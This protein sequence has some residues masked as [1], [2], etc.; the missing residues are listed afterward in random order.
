M[1][2]KDYVKTRKEELDRF[3]ETWSVGNSKDPENWPMTNSEAEW[4]EQ[5]IADLATHG[6]EI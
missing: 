2:L 3:A 6:K 5:E 4:F 1:D